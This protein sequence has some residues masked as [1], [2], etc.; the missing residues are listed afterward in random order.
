MIVICLQ[1]RLM[2]KFGEWK[3]TSWKVRWGKVALNESKH[4]TLNV[5]RVVLVTLIIVDKCIHFYVSRRQNERQSVKLC[6]KAVEI[7]P[8]TCQ[9]YVTGASYRFMYCHQ[10]YFHTWNILCH[11]NHIGRCFKFIETKA[12]KNWIYNQNEPEHYLRT[13]RLQDSVRNQMV[14]KH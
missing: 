12:K 6:Q 14:M 8:T 11:T 10:P 7:S 2:Q 13:K 1:K 4:S 3:G 5:L 9:V